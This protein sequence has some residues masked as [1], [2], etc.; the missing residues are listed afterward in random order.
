MRKKLAISNSNHEFWTDCDW[1]KKKQQTIFHIAH[2]PDFQPQNIIKYRKIHFVC[3]ATD[4]SFFQKY[5]T[6]EVSINAI[7]FAWYIVENKL[8]A[9][10]VLWYLF[11]F[12]NRMKERERKQGLNEKESVY[13]KFIITTQEQ[14]QL[15]ILKTKANR[16]MKWIQKRP[17]RRN[18]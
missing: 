11:V 7:F 13:K 14:N 9:I 2:H 6:I 15:K 8:C 3:G 4:S 5:P 10:C 17:N 18:A 12:I 1:C 16:K